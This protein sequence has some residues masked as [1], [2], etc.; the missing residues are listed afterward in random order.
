MNYMMLNGKKIELTAEQAEEIKRSFEKTQIKLADIE[1]GKTFKV[2]DYEFIVLEQSENAAAVILKALYRNSEFFGENNNYDGSNVDAICKD[3]GCEIEKIIGEENL[4]KHTVNLTADDG[5]KCYGSIER[6]MSLLTANLYR[7]YVDLLDE[8]KIDD[9]WWTAT[10]YSTPKHD[11]SSWVKC[12]SPR[13]G[14]HNSD[15]YDIISGV[16][17]FCI[18]NSNIFVSKVEEK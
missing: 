6:K 5:L 17:P 13:G 9:W 15:S 7:K 2:G 12:V 10:A 4:I 1:A 14:I 3:F 18:L 16:R 11:N 8:Y